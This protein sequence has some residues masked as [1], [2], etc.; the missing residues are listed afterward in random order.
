MAGIGFELKRLFEVDQNF[1]PILTA[2]KSMV[3]SSGPWILAVVTVLCIQIMVRPVL[4]EREYQSLLCII[5]YSF[6]FSMILTSPL[7]QMAIRYTSD[8]IYSRQEEDILAVFLGAALVIGAPSLALSYWYVSTYTEIPEMAY[9]ASIFYAS[10]SLMWLAMVFVGAMRS[11]NVVTFSFLAGMII[12]VTGTYFWGRTS[13]E[14]SIQSFALG[15]QVTL[16]SLVAILLREK[17][18]R[19]L[20]DFNWLGRLQLVPLAVSGLLF[21]LMIWSDK[22]IFWF[23]ST[24][25]TEVLKGFFFFPEYDYAVFLASLTIIPTTAY[26]SVFV[27]TEFAVAQRKFLDAASYGESLQ[28]VQEHSVQTYNVFMK[29]IFR[30][31]VF[32]CMIMLGFL[33]ICPYLIENLGEG[34]IILPILKITTLNV[35]IQTLI[36]AGTVFLYYFDFQKEVILVTLL[37]FTLN[38]IFSFWMLNSPYEATGYSYFLTLIITLNVTIITAVYKISRM[39]FYTFMQ[40]ELT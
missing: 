18:P 8:I 9:S 37:G 4:D 40:A 34:L 30:L 19:K 27:E 3:I 21:Q 5:V 17:R 11:Y 10:L 39:R 29:G 22:M 31:F 32:Q 35:C 23:F 15:I 13:A 16:F 2:V 28:S 38:C 33:V 20:L 26:F 12:A 36:Q 6:V 7:I 1:P 14:A 25:S 24:H